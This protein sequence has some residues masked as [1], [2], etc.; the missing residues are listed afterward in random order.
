MLDFF[1]KVVSLQSKSHKLSVLPTAVPTSALPEQADIQK[2]NYMYRD[3][4]LYTSTALTLFFNDVRIFHSCQLLPHT[5]FSLC[6]NQTNSLIYYYTI[7]NP[8]Y[9]KSFF[10]PYFGPS[11]RP[12]LERPWALLYTTI[13]RSRTSHL[14]TLRAPLLHIFTVLRSVFLTRPRCGILVSL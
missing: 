12:H 11:R 8:G 14:C 2:L 13:T 7:L 4:I 9:Q 1:Q 6:S 5:Q 3:R 10:M